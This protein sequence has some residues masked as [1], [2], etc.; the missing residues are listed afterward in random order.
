MQRMGAMMGEKVKTMRAA[1]PLRVAKLMRRKGG[2]EEV[3]E[4][5]NSTSE[6]KIR[7]ASENGMRVKAQISQHLHAYVP[8]LKEAVNDAADA[9]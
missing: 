6:T 7:A 5:N 8:V 3:Q 1:S 4:G 9:E 2:E